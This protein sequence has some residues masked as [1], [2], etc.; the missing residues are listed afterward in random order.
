VAVLGR[1]QA[2]EQRRLAGPEARRA[3]AFEREERVGVPGVPDQREEGEGDELQE[4][5]EDERVAASYLVDE[6]AGAQAGDERGGPADGE[7]E[8]GLRERDPAH[9]VQVDDREGEHDPVPE[10]VHDATHLYEPDHARQVRVEPAQ[11]GRQRLH[12]WF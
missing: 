9:V 10:R 5:A 4:Q 2:C 12:R 6:R 8:A 1:G 11:V 7:R 3:D